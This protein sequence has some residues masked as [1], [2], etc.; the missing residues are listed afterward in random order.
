MKVKNCTDCPFMVSKYDGWS[1]G[2]DTVVSCQYSVFLKHPN[3]IITVFDSFEENNL[4][5]MPDWCPLKENSINIEL[6]HD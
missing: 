2:Y 6:D 4:I 5:N 3:S 1:M